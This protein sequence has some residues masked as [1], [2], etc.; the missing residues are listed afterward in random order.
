MFKYHA[1]DVANHPWRLS[2][3]SSIAI[4]TKFDSVIRN[5]AGKKKPRKVH[6]STFQSAVLVNIK[7]FKNILL[8]KNLMVNVI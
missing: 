8:S 2:I 7:L 1:C 4:E 5:F 6:F 3:E